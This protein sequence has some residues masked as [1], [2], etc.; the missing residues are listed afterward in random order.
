M[1]VAGQQDLGHPEYD[2]DISSPLFVLAT[3]PV[4]TRPEG[5]PRLWGN[6]KIKILPDTLSHRIYGQ[7]EI[8]EPHSCNFE[9]NPDY[10]EI[11]EKSGAKIC[12]VSANGT[13]S[14]VE[15]PDHSFYVTTGFLPQLTS[16]EHNPHPLIVAYLEAS[17]NYQKEA[18][19]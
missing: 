4:E 11:L 5:A 17:K 16:E 10:K 3:C 15:F 2:P 8:E 18:K 1:N 19:T 7:F 13:A 14:I 12:G 6:L 9:L